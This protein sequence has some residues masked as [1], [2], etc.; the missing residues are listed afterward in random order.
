MGERSTYREANHLLQSNFWSVC[1]PW[2]FA[3][4]VVLQLLLWCLK[5]ILTNRTG[6]STTS[7]TVLWYPPALHSTIS[8]DICWDSP[9]LWSWCVC[10]SNLHPDCP[11]G[12]KI[13]ESSCKGE[14]RRP[15][16]CLEKAHWNQS[17]KGQQNLDLVWSLMAKEV[18][19]HIFKQMPW[20]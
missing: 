11:T 18:C 9:D 16:T 3:V 19:R 7:T 15:W 2:E 4:L 17:I 5:T 1:A 14:V 6:T 12:R 8:I 20:K 13:K 10:Y